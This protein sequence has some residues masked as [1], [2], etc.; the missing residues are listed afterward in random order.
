MT[1]AGKTSR[2]TDWFLSRL[3]DLPEANNASVLVANLSR[4]VID[5]NRP[6]DDA[7]MYPG[8][9]TTGLI[10]EH[11][12]DGQAI[13]S[14]ATPVE[15]EKQRRIQEYWQPYHDALQDELT[16]LRQEHGYAV[17]LEAH[18]IASIVPRLFDG[19]LPDLNFGTNRGA[20]CDPTLLRQIEAIMSSQNQ[21]SFVSNDRF[22]GGHITRHFGQPAE[23]WHSL[24][25][26][27]SQATYMNENQLSWDDAKAAAVQK[28]LNQILAAL[29]RWSPPQ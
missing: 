2:D 9:T 3:Y 27:L 23:N 14:S 16:R 12:F 24:Q 19:Q 6:V 17:L 20:S 11:C 8:Q 22:V 10:P 5:L 18:S 15:H 7:S 1:E 13:Y 29:K 25:I 4:Y 28:L 26:E 21:Y